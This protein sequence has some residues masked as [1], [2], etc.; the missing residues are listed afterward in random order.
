MPIETGQNL[1]HN[2]AIWVLGAGDRGF[3]KPQRYTYRCLRCQW[4]FIVND[5]YRPAQFA[6]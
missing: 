1:R 5:E 4:T 3:F 2:F 6:L